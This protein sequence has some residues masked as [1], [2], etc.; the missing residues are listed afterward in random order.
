MRYYLAAAFAFALT[1][2]GG[3]DAG[4]QDVLDQVEALNRDV[5]GEGSTAGLVMG[6]EVYPGS[7]VTTNMSSAELSMVMFETNDGTDDILSY[8]RGEAEQRGFEVTE[9]ESTSTA[10]G[11][12]GKTADGAEINVHVVDN[13]DT[14]TGDM[15]IRTK[16]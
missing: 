6:F 9:Y 16:S 8:Y 5:T 14:R 3:G 15:S 2:C 13:G 12:N 11:I 4:E 1:A 7:E 10:R